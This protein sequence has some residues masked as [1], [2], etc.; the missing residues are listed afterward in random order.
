MPSPGDETWMGVLALRIWLYYAADGARVVFTADP[1]A[2]VRE[3]MSR[4]LFDI[5]HDYSLEVE[6]ESDLW[7]VST[8][9]QFHSVS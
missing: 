1:V 2:L 5:N 9:S 6:T 4:I 3:N 7:R 8:I